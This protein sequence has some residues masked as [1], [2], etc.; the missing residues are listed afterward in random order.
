MQRSIF[1][2]IWLVTALANMCFAQPSFDPTAPFGVLSATTELTGR[3]WHPVTLINSKAVQAELR[4]TPDQLAA[5]ATY[6]NEV[7]QKLSRFSSSPALL[8]DIPG[9]EPMTTREVE[10]ARPAVV[11]ALREKLS[12]ILTPEQDKRLDQLAWRCRGELALFDE[13]LAGLLQLRPETRRALAD[14]EKATSLSAP[15]VQKAG[16]S[17]TT[18]DELKARILATLTPEERVR[19]DDLIGAPVTKEALRLEPDAYVLEKGHW[20]G[21]VAGSRSPN[22]S[23]RMTRPGM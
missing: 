14:L 7:R 6:R 23:S 2:V 15:G 19:W 11:A 21:L 5:L 12:T 16:D 13:D 20:I 17:R 22:A 1:L 10:Q 3:R 18:P 4:V 9:A 8:R